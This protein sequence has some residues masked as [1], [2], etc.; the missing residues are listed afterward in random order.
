MFAVVAR[1][2]LPEGGNME[3]GREMLEKN[4]IPM[5]RQSPGFVAGYWLAPPDGREGLSVVIYEDEPSARTAADGLQPPPPVRL[6][7]VEVRAVAASAT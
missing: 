5:V 6:L 3:Q 7:S 2:E 4:V 1:V